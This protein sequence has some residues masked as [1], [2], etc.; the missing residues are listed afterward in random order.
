MSSKPKGPI[1]HLR[2]GL[3]ILLAFILC[4]A[5]AEAA[6]LGILWSL[7]R[8]PSS[9]L[10]DVYAAS[11]NEATDT[12]LGPYMPLVRHPYFGHIRD[13]SRDPRINNYGFFDEQ[14][15]PYLKKPN[16]FV[17][18]VFG[19]SVATQWAE[20]AKAHD[21]AKL[22][23]DTIPD[24]AQRQLI[25]LNFG[26]PGG[27]QPQ[28]FII[29]AYFANT[30]DLALNVDGFNEMVWEDRRYPSDFPTSY[31]FHNGPG[32][33]DPILT[34][35]IST[36][37]TWE[38][39]L[40]ESAMKHRLWSKSPSFFLFWQ[41][42]RSAKVGL[43]AW[44]EQSGWPKTE[45]RRPY[46]PQE[47]RQT[48]LDV[49]R[50][51]VNRWF[52]WVS[53]EEQVVRAQGRSALFFV[54]PNPYVPPAKPFSDEERRIALGHQGLQKI[55]PELAIQYGL[56]RERIRSQPQHRTNIFDLTGIFQNTPTA[57]YKD[58]L[59]HLNETGNW[60]LSKKIAETIRVQWP[61]LNIRSHKR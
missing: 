35:A 37:R 34:F 28:Q 19:G 9:T 14:D 61:A 21:F 43:I 25:I 6:S 57:V 56:I 11:R 2:F 12:G 3:W 33:P 59:G 4:V 54:I 52:H 51:L 5:L 48:N 30:V 36:L 31:H 45:S 50:G 41:T 55:S 23:A 39:T 40:S 46:Q 10:R 38:S 24:L 15:F 18:G 8:W 16:D 13:K 42:C 29:S 1:A 27:E 49:S 20:F 58:F 32:R 7:G 22:L 26:L 44:I 17:I 53:L 60:L 47:N